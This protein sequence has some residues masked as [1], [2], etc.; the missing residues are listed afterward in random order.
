[1]TARFVGDTQGALAF[2]KSGLE[3]DP[4]HVGCLEA[5]ARTQSEFGLDQEAETTWRRLLERNAESPNAHAEM[6]RIMLRAGRFEEAYQHASTVIR[7]QPDSAT[8]RELYSEVVGHQHPLARFFLWSAKLWQGNLL[9][10]M[11]A[12]GL[13]P[14]LSLP[15]LPPGTDKRIEAVLAAAAFFFCFGFAFY[16]AWAILAAET[17]I[18]HSAQF[19]RL[20]PEIR[21]QRSIYAFAWVAA[22]VFILAVLLSAALMNAHPFL[23]AGNAILIGVVELIAR[24]SP[25]P[26]KGFAARFAIII[27]AA[28]EAIALFGPEEIVRALPFAVL[29]AWCITV[30]APLIITGRDA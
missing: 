18:A 24:W 15:L 16:G 19:S 28:V 20:Q 17:I 26:R 22:L 14:L 23:L 5:L 1:M 30:A 10:I 3:I 25:D 4:E 11:V 27:P 12:I 21:A 2:A 7:Q 6:A 29:P 13:A 8:I 9:V